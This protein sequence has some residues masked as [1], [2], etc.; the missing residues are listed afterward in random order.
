MAAFNEYGTLPCQLWLARIPSLA[1]RNGQECKSLKNPMPEKRRLLCYSTTHNIIE[2]KGVTCLCEWSKKLPDNLVAHSHKTLSW[3]SPSFT[4]SGYDGQA[5]FPF[6]VQLA[7]QGA[8]RQ[9]SASILDHDHTIRRFL[10]C[11]QPPTPFLMWSAEKC[12]PILTMDDYTHC[13]QS[14]WLGSEM[15]DRALKVGQ[16]FHKNTREPC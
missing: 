4:N 11:C 9:T 8:K 2:R 15:L 7:L 10:R 5:A 16:I 13:S 6:G 14:S 12:V 1:K 3:V